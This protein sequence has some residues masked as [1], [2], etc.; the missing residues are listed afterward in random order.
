MPTNFITTLPSTIFSISTIT[1]SLVTPPSPITPLPTLRPTLTSISTITSSQNPFTA[2]LQAINIIKLAQ[3]LCSNNIITPNCLPCETVA[4]CEPPT[5]D[6]F[7]TPYPCGGLCY[8]FYRSQENNE[9]I[10]CIPF[11]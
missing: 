1:S 8:A 4:L 2:P 5:S 10:S 9:P 7:C 3:R 11:L 6:I